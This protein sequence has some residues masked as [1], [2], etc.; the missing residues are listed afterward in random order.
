MSESLVKKAHQRLF[1]LRSLKKHHL[2]SDILVNF[3]RCTIKSILT[4]CVTV[5]YGNCS[6]SDRKALQKVVKTAQRIA[7]A[8]LPSIEDIYRRRCHRRA[9]KVTKDSCHPAH[10]LFTLMPSGKCYR[11]LRTKTT[12]FRNSFFPTAVSLLNSNPSHFTS[13]QAQ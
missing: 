2:S 9:K 1:F 4:S 13:L 3:Y 6:A 10:G 12:R 5:W 11:S 8:S 7:G